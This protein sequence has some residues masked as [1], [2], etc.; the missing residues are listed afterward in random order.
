MLMAML[1]SPIPV[2]LGTGHSKVIALFPRATTLMEAGADGRVAGVKV[3]GVLATPLPTE[4][5]AVTVIA[6]GAP[7][8]R[9]VSV[10]VVTAPTV[11]V[12]TAPALSMDIEY[13]VMALQP[14]SAGA[15]QEIVR[16]F[17]AY[18]DESPCATEV[19]C[20]GEKIADDETVDPVSGR[21]P[22]AGA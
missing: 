8:V 22:A 19:V 6:T 3:T 15:L 13:P 17:A 21:A 11:L 9:M 10:V 2:S 5:T 4:F 20:M 16:E 1:V 12:V 14:K 7:G 18:V